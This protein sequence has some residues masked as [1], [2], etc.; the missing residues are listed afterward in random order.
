[1]V[2]AVLVGAAHRC[3]VGL[4]HLGPHGVLL[5]EI[6]VDRHDR[7]V[8]EIRRVIGLRAVE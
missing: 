8:D 4:A 5:A 1:M 7:A 3:V 6:A 2:V